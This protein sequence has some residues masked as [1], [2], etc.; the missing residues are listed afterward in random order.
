[1]SGWKWV[2]IT[3]A[4]YLIAGRHH[5][6]WLRVC[7][8]LI[9]FYICIY[10]LWEYWLIVKKIKH[11]N[12][13]EDERSLQFE[14]IELVALH[15][16]AII[17]LVNFFFFLLLLRLLSKFELIVIRIVKKKKTKGTNFFVSDF[18]K[19][20]NGVNCICF[21]LKN[22]SQSEKKKNKKEWNTNITE[23]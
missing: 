13:R 22:K 1:M 7:L 4:K 2:R 23:N 20:L 17:S 19:S 3:Y 8:A 6:H 14:I 10:K 9:S 18:V 21:V 15:S 12:L 16:L 5:Q 11:V